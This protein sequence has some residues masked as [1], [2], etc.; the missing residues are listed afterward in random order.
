MIEEVQS[1]PLEQL[2]AKYLGMGNV[3]GKLGGMILDRAAAADIG[4][5]MIPSGQRIA[6]VRGGD[7]KGFF[8][9]L[10]DKEL[11]KVLYTPLQEL[12][13][14]VYS[15]KGWMNIDLSPEFRQKIR[16]GALTYK[17]GGLACLRR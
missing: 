8:R 10:Y 15:D 13:A 17:Q 1:D 16:E 3:Y 4:R 12:G 9:D 6:E 14:P 7:R 2:G 5:V 11:D